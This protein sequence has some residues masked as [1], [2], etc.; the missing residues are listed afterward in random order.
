MAFVQLL[1]PPPVAG[2]E[3]LVTVTDP[4][5][6]TV[7]ESVYVG[8]LLNLAVAVDAELPIGNWQV[9]LVP[10]QAPLQLVN[11]ESG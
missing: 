11:T 9:L 4:P 7:A 1:M 8:A 2:D 3:L 5:L 10:E 6:L